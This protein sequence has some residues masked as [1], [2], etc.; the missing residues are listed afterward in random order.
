[1]TNVEHLGVR[2]IGILVAVHQVAVP[3]LGIDIRLGLALLIEVCGIFLGLLNPDLIL[4]SVLL[5]Q[6]VTV[7]LTVT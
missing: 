2:Y 1:M 3:A 5:G 6:Q 7:H 4:Y